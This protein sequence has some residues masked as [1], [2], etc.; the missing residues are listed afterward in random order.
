MIPA[1][2]PAVKKMNLTGGEVLARAT[3]AERVNEKFGREAYSLR[4]TKD[5]VEIEGGSPIAIQ[6][7]KSTLEQIML[8]CPDKMPFMEIE[9]APAFAY[10]SFHLDC[11]RHFIPLDE[12]K[13]M[14]ACCAHFKKNVFHWHFSDDQG[15]RIE[16]KAYPLLHEIG[17]TRAGDHFGS[18]KS[19]EVER[20]FYTREQ[21]KELVAYCK[22]LGIEVVPEIDIPGH[23]TAILAAYPQLGCKGTKVE[24]ATKAGIFTDILCPGKEETFTFLE[25]LIDDLLELFPGEYFHIGGDETPKSSWKTCPHCQKRMEE[26]H[27]ENVQ[28]LQGYF[29]NRVAA[30]LKKRGRTSIVWNEAA[31]GGNLDTDVVVQ[32]WNDGNKLNGNTIDGIGKEWIS[33][34][35]KVILSPM[36][37]CYFDYPHGFISLKNAT[38]LS[39]VPVRM[40]PARMTEEE[41]ERILGCECLL[42]TE[43]VREWERLEM[44]AWPRFAANAEIGWCGDAHAD[45]VDFKKRMKQIFPIFEKYRIAATKPSGW[46]PNPVEKARQLL[47]MAGNFPKD[48]REGFSKQQEEI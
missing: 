29:N 9:D 24:V 37:N 6:Y 38:G 5:G 28:Q 16:S 11:A 3:V 14:I 18:Y 2:V 34:G 32:L 15:W 17:G 43:Y 42:W 40:D 39:M 36:M 10:R 41:K 46:V 21:V 47:E 12:L 45:Y 8:Q 1:I 27:L 26:E 48:V 35:G 22:E 7:A 31:L 19:D 44:F 23:V 33:H 30:H 25:A 4:I 20:G 13:K